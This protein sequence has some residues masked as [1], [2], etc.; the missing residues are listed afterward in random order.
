MYGPNVAVKRTSMTTPL[1]KSTHG[2]ISAPAC[3]FN[4]DHTVHSG[5]RGVPEVQSGEGEQLRGVNSSHRF[6]AVWH[7]LVKPSGLSRDEWL[8]TQGQ[9]E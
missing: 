6:D 7:N 4:G 5:H 8:G 2:S 1:K 9:G 3:Q